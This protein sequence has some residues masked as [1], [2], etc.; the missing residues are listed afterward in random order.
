MEIAIIS[1]KGGTGKSSISA[2]FATI[3]EKVVLA[4]GDVDASNLP[5]IFNPICVEEVKYTGSEK[6]VVNSLLCNLCCLCEEVCRF[7]AISIVKGALT[8]SE[9][10]CDGCQLCARLCPEGAI[11]MV[12]NDKSRLL[13]GWF[14]NGK[15]VYGRLAP[16]EENTGK[17]V[18]LV[19]EKAQTIAQIEGIDTIIIDGPPGIS[20]PV[21]SSITGVDHVVIVA[22]PSISCAL[23]LM[24]AIEL[25]KKFH[26]KT[27]V[28]LN[29]YDLNA[30]MTRQIE[31]TC[32]SMGIPVIGKLPFDPQIIEAMV[33]CQSMIE[34]APDSIVSRLRGFVFSKC[35][36][37]LS[38]I[39]YAKRSPEIRAVAK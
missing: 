38:N 9:L 34:W 32:Q 25:T 22:E 1:G 30:E 29:K 13:T 12:T 39:Q 27:W 36:I 35:W 4:D 20:C 7:N 16:G 2:A 18:N 33:H 5:L 3:P 23:D 31:R 10:N 26:G 19:R 28:I 37:P 21:I 6:A 8:I 24:R 11:S 15:M 17:L 14:R